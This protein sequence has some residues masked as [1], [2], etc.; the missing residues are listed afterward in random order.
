VLTSEVSTSW[1]RRRHSATLELD[2]LVGFAGTDNS[3]GR[4]AMVRQATCDAC[5]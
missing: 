2:F 1:E 5:P 3:D 4:E